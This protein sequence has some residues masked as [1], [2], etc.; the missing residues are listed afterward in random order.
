MQ[1]M[2]LGNKLFNW[3]NDCLPYLPTSP[4]QKADQNIFFNYNEFNSIQ[5]AKHKKN[6]CS[7]SGLAHNMITTPVA[8]SLFSFL[9][10]PTEPWESPVAIRPPRR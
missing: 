4:S 10:L 3:S 2:S 9:S 5:F 1:W 7:F 8:A 6:M